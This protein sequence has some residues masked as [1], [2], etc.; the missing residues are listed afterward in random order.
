MLIALRERMFVV[1]P[2]SRFFF[3]T[4]QITPLQLSFSGSNIWPL[5]SLK[6]EN[7]SLKYAV[8]KIRSEERR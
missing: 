7:H 8:S 1:A 4:F 3:S 2:Q 6:G 5:L